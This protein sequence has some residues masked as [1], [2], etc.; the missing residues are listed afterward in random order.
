VLI[1]EGKERIGGGLRT[2]ELTLPGFKHDICSAIHPL[3]A[4]SPFLTT[5][6]LAQFGLE[7]IYPDVAAA[8][9]LDDGTA[10][11]LTH[12]VNDTARHLGVDEQAYL[13][14]VQPLIK[15]WNAI[16]PDVLGPLHWPKHPLAMAKFGAKALLPA[17][18]LAK[19]FAGTPARALIAGM[20]AHAIQ[21]LGNLTTAAIALVLLVQGHIKG[22]PLPKGGS[23]QI[24][25][26]MAGYFESI[27]GKIETG[28]FISSM[29]Q[30]PSARAVLFDV[31][32]R[33]LL[34]I[35]GHRFSWVYKK[36]LAR[37]RYGM[38]VFKIDWA[39][40]EPVPFTAPECRSAG[41]LHL[42]GS[43]E[44]IA[45]S[46][47]STSKG[48]HPEQPYVLFAQQSLF[49]NSRAPNGKHTAWAYCHVPHGSEKDMTHIIEN[50][51]ERFA[52]GFKQCIIARSTMNTRQMEEYNPNYMG[53][54]INGGQLDITQLFTRPALRWSPYRTSAKGLYI[55]SSST[56]PGGG[57]HGMCGYYAAKRA[58]KEVFGIRIN[59]LN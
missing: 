32:P 31:T 16:A 24:A 17:S 19:V 34:Q 57:V 28:I 47:L 59:T 27:G 11:M 4:N 52:P 41:T 43:F 49:D 23:Q 7:Y 9:P 26:A 37:Y 50:Q 44:Q 22:W 29:S 3:G 46:E 18:V 30:L 42:G 14:L 53:G 39:L 2:A 12:S 6:P 54:D 8:H 58:L 5:L 21:P 56:P 20:A 35:A 51:V 15:S 36:Q 40:N 55:C 25:N 33:Q 1:I 10:A 13:K 48:N 45:S 38:G